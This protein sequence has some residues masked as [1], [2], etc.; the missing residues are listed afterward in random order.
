MTVFYVANINDSISLITIDIHIILET[1][2]VLMNNLVK[3]CIF[4]EVIK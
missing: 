3:N 1:I 2:C 4:N